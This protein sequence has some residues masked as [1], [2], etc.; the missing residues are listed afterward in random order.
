MGVVG[1]DGQADGRTDV[2]DGRLVRRT[3]A[4]SNCQTCRQTFVTSGRWLGR[5]DG[6]GPSENV[7]LGHQTTGGRLQNKRVAR[8]DRRTDGRTADVRDCRSRRMDG[9]WFARTTHRSH[10]PQHIAPLDRGSRRPS[11]GSGLPP[12]PSR[13]RERLPI[14]FHESI[15][16]VLPSEITGDLF[17][18]CACACDQNRKLLFRT[19]F[20][21]VLCA[22]FFFLTKVIHVWTSRRIVASWL[23]LF[24]CKR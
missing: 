17:S 2:R 12:S 7:G 5:A 21:D 23:N 16:S 24:G 14:L 11:G 22:T 18:R 9:R 13:S 8:S 20:A 1:T 15:F 6:L 3:D 10:P 4:R 19:M